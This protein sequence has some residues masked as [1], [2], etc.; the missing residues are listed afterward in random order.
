MVV[1]RLQ[2]NYLALSVFLIQK[3]NSLLFLETINIVIC[4]TSPLGSVFCVGA[5]P[6]FTSLEWLCYSI[7]QKP[8]PFLF[9]CR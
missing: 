2:I 7:I 4:L 3:H 8:R 1:E 9:Q 6:L 5:R